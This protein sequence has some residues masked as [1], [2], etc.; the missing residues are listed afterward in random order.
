MLVFN[1]RTL[2]VEA[3]LVYIVRPILKGEGLGGKEDILSL[4]N[5]NCYLL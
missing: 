5:L 3:G 4:R 1:P 2:E